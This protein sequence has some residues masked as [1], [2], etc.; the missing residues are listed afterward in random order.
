MKML[1]NRQSPELRRTVRVGVKIGN[2]MMML[3]M[4]MM[5][6]AANSVGGLKIG[7]IMMMMDR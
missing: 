1:K 2:M 4:M 7:K 5:M 6:M 3:M